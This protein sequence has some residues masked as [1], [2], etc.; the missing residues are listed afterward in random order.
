MVVTKTRE[1]AMS[2]MRRL[3]AVF[4][5]VS[6]TFG[7]GPSLWAA[8]D[9]TGAPRRLEIVDLLM[10]RNFGTLERILADAAADWDAFGHLFRY[11][12]PAL[13]E[14]LDAWVAMN[15]HAVVPRL[16]RGSYHLHIAHLKRGTKFA[17]K[18]HARQFGLMNGHFDQAITDFNAAL[19]TDPAIGAAHAARISMAI[20]RSGDSADFFARQALAKAPNSAAVHRELLRAME[21]RWGGQQVAVEAYVERLLKTFGADDE[22]QA[23][24]G[25][26]EAALASSEAA[27]GN[28][29]S[30]LPLID[31]AITAHNSAQR[32]A[33]RA[34]ILLAMDRS[35][36]A[37]A[38]ITNAIALAPDSPD[39]LE[40]RAVAKW[41]MER[42]DA[43]LADLDRAIELNP[44]VP[45]FLLRR[46]SVLQLLAARA[47]QAEN[48]S[49]QVTFLD[50]AEQ[51][52]ERALVH[53]AFDADVHRALA[54]FYSGREETGHM[55][56]VHYR[57]AIELWPGEPRGWLDLTQYLFATNDCSAREAAET[58]LQLCKMARDCEAAM[59]FVNVVQSEMLACSLPTLPGGDPMPLPPERSEQVQMM[60]R[61][62]DLFGT[63]D[64]QR[65]IDHCAD[66]AQEGDKHAQFDLGLLYM[67]G[68]PRLAPR[69]AE[70]RHTALALIWLERADKQG[71][72]DARGALGMMYLY[73]FSVPADPQKGIV[74]LREAAEKDSARSLVMLADAYSRG[75]GV[76]SDEA[77]ARKLLERARNLGDKEAAEKLK[78]LDDAG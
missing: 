42:L 70:G 71:V 9:S 58:Y 14:P 39:H 65:A 69:S 64:D 35:E 77:E 8:D 13:A 48:S 73:G 36:E 47:G 63:M 62:G 61:C 52:L 66:L 17:G 54:A 1:V 60:H 24:A 28:L 2:V 59:H 6:A 32:Q 18:T 53:G 74:M 50:R 30:A 37:L 67:Q 56:T 4:L 33:Q 76:A 68:I 40:A 3:I 12:D 49:A 45:K 25:Y 43:A 38:A 7:Q 16:A 57:K 21:P 72:A 22:F 26:A 31:M 78:R 20:T 46:A 75:I 10:S 15:P 5:I 44:F 41:R 19:A 23:F 51:D 27:R 11:S 34:E 29:A 55:A